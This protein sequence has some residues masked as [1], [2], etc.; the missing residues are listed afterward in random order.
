[1]DKLSLIKHILSPETPEALPIATLSEASPA[2]PYQVGE[3]YFIRTVTHHYAGRLTDVTA[4]EL[5]LRECCWIADD[6]RFSDAM[7]SGEHNEVE[8]FPEG[9]VIIGRGSIID[10][11]IRTAALPSSKK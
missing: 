10:A 7:K 8:P 5:V 9:N 1:M 6:G 3:A 11:H 4:T 2:H